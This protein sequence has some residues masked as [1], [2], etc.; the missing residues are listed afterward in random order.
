MYKS[1]VNGKFQFELSSEE[2]S[3]LLKQFNAV[4]ENDYRYHIIRNN[5]S[6]SIDLVKYDKEVKLLSL[7]VN[8]NK[9]ECKLKDRQDELLERLGMDK[10]NSKK[11][12]N[13]KAPM[14][15]L[16]LNVLVGEGTAVKKGDAL[17]ILEAMKME[18]ILKSPTD[19]VVKK[20]SANKGTPVEKNQILI[21][22]N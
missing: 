22:F 9:Y 1:K 10:A 17:I 4:K 12:N 5:V 18:N 21:E 15:G 3:D 14:P 13:V 11:V 2:V 6:Y 7:K 8:G 20:V 16:V 19:G